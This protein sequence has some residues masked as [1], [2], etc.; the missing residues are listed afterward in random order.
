MLDE[1][2]V[3]QA[4][5]ITSTT[6]DGDN[7]NAVIPMLSLRFASNPT[8]TRK[9]IT[10]SGAIGTDSEVVT[11]PQWTW[12]TPQWVGRFAKPEG[13]PQASAVQVWLMTPDFAQ[14]ALAIK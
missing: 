4:V 8:I 14:E 1:Q 10:V 11:I 5:V 13:Q 9:S 2:N 3:L 6:F 7:I 12:R